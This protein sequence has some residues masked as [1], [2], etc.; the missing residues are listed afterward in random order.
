MKTL[1]SIYILISSYTIGK[2][3]WASIILGSTYL[4]CDINPPNNQSF[5]PNFSTNFFSLSSWKR[6]QKKYW[7]K[8]DFLSLS[9]FD[10]LFSFSIAQTEKKFGKTKLVV[11]CDEQAINLFIFQVWCN[12]ILQILFFSNDIFFR[13]WCACPLVLQF[14]AWK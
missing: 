12:A 7:F 11:W 1:F 5:F 9:V 3:W 2:K 8:A 6:K 13:N 14:Q 4:A 10:S